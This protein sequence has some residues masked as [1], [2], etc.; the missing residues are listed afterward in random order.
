MIVRRLP[1]ASVKVLK[2]GWRTFS[3][4][5]LLASAF[6]TPAYGQARDAKAFRVVPLPQRERFITR[7]NQYV[8]Y[9][10]TSQQDKLSELYDE[11]TL[12]SLCK[13]KP[14]CVG[15]CHLPGVVE[16]PEGFSAVLLEL[17]PRQVEPYKDE[18]W[19][20]QIEAEQ[21][22]RVSW[23]GRAPHTVKKKVILFAVY[24]NGDWHFS[25][26]SEPHMVWL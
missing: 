26:I 12:C 1:V 7:L 8:E 4:T 23:K 15:G 21:K 22:E 6:F 13:G 2:S 25:P 16:V 5:C 10:R 11:D 14:E 3:I 9:L 17:K 24:Q 18:Y 19:Q 20:Y